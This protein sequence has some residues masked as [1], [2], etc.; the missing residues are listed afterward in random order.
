MKNLTPI[1]FLT[2]TMLGTPS[3]LRAEDPDNVLSS[4]LKQAGEAAKKVKMQ[5]SDVK[6][7]MEEN[8]KEE[9]R[10]K[11]AKQAVVDAPGPA[12][13][14][15]WTPKTP[16]FTPAGPV[17]RK[18]IEGEPVTALM[19]TSPLAPAEIAD[20]WEK[21]VANQQLNHGRNNMNI[22]GT[23]S[24]ILYLHSQTDPPVEVHLEAKRAPDEKITH[25]TVTSPLAVPKAADDDD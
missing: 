23:L 18:L 10:E 11:A 3:L 20:S 16:Q 14:P 1:A 21:A 6:K 9:A 22:N 12:Q 17:A 5:M 8:D 13:L 4:A 15:S 2:L 24:V 25:V 19:G 7:I